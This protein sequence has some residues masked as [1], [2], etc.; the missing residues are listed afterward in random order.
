MNSTPVKDCSTSLLMQEALW[1]PAQGCV[2][3]HKEHILLYHEICML[4]SWV[5]AKM[6]DVHLTQVRQ[7]NSTNASFCSLLA[8]FKGTVQESF[9]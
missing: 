6:C 7:Y 3:R 8:P 1:Y 9:K 4:A 5:P 2:V